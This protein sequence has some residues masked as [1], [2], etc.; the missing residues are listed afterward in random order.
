MRKLL[1]LL[2]LLLMPLLTPAQQSQFTAPDCE[3]GFTYLVTGG[4]IAAQP[5]P[6]GGTRTPAAPVIPIVAGYDN[7][8]KG[9]ITWTVTY[10]TEGVGAVSLELDGAPTAAGIPGS[11]VT[12]PAPAPGT[13]FPVTTLSQGQAT[14]YQFQPWVSIILNSAT[15]TGTVYGRVVG[16]RPQAG[17]DSTAIGLSVAAVNTDP[18]Q[19]SAIIKRSAFANITT[20]TTTAL[21]TPV[22][23][24]NVT[25]CG[26]T[27]DMVATV[28]ADTILLEQG[29]GATCGG[30]PTALTPAFSSGVL[31]SGGTVVSFGHAGQMVFKTTAVNNGICAVTTVGTGPSIAVHITFVQQP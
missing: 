5:A 20:A 28:T 23:A 1:L 4:S 22:A 21:V 19:S 24:Q 10:Q 8:F 2:A 3:F 6:L 13:V 15:G 14:A 30:A 18:C 12:W 7:R 29:T 11:W 17:Q 9:C 25:V 27:V 31:T 16:W 26:V